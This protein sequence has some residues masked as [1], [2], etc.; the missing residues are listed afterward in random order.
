MIKVIDIHELKPGHFLVGFE[1]IVK[2]VRWTNDYPFVTFVGGRTWDAS[3]AKEVSIEVSVQ[4][5]TERYQARLD[6]ALSFWKEAALTGD[7]LNARRWMK[8]ACDF[9]SEL[10]FGAP[11]FSPSECPKCHGQNLT[12]GDM[13]HEERCKWYRPFVCDCGA[14]GREFFQVA[15]VNSVLT[16]QL[17][18]ERYVTTKTR[19]ITLEACFRGYCDNVPEALIQKEFER[20]VQ[21]FEA[22]DHI[23][24]DDVQ[25]WFEGDQASEEFSKMLDGG[26]HE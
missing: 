1:K 12:Y 2:K 4:P 15:Y 23:G 7:E 17:E 21:F 14:T 8:I 25:Y 16:N 24:P 22:H 20:L 19:R 3:Q 18:I 13:V 10:H 26:D 9:Q 6:G 5:Y 11:I